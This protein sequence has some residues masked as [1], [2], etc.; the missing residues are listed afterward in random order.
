MNAM[1]IAL[2]TGRYLST[3]DILHRMVYV[4]GKPITPSKDVQGSV[5]FRKQ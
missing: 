2:E 4:F 3:E 1:I 5:P